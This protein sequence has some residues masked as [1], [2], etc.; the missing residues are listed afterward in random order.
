VKRRL[1]ALEENGLIEKVDE[2]RGYYKITERGR[3]YLSGDL[4]AGELEKDH[5]E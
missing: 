4:D 5:T 2:K 3:G 1:P